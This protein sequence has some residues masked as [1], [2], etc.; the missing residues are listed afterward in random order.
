MVNSIR[1]CLI[2]LL[3]LIIPGLVS[4]KEL[5]LTGLDIIDR[6]LITQEVLSELAYMRMSQVE[7]DRSAKH[8]QVLATFR[9]NEDASSNYLLRMMEP[10]EVRSVSLLVKQFVNGGS[11]QY[12]YLP[13]VGRAR[14]LTGK[15]KNQKFLGTNF[16]L[17]DLQ[18]EVPAIHGYERQ[19]D[20]L[21]FGRACYQ[22]RAVEKGE[23]D[24]PPLYL[25]RDLHIDQEN[26][27]LLRVD[28]YNM[29]G[30][31]I[32]Q[33]SLYDYKSPMVRGITKR[34]H[35][36]VMQNLEDGS[37]TVFS[38]IESRIDQAIGAEIFTPDNIETWTEEEIESFV[39]DYGLNLG[40]GG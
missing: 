3:T 20:T 21:V 4:A 9:F 23:D 7:A 8:Y 36:A 13:T 37:T 30:T 11:Q 33:L 32:K 18:R 22:V 6:Y 17:A 12:L 28:Y 29:D 14:P 27:N 31:M 10:E 1:F 24:R 34:P 35:R 26:Y 5:P 15:S 40:T 19:E 38:V 39:F 16:T 25:H 2:G